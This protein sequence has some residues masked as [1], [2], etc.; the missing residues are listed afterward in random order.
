MNDEYTS[1]V[2]G[3]LSGPH[4]EALAW[5][6]AGPDNSRSLG[7]MSN[8]ESSSL[9]NQLYALGAESVIAVGLQSENAAWCRYLLVQLPARSDY[10]SA[11]F[12]FERRNVEEHGYEGQADEGQEYLFIDT[13]LFA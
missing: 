9:L 11:L 10:R 5:L 13:K 4:T 2:R 3:F 6:R 7:E 8:S 1:I 12:A